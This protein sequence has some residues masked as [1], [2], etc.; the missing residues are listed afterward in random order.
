[1]APARI[2]A[3]LTPPRHVLVLFG[4]SIED[5]TWTE[6]DLSRRDSTVEPLPIQ[7]PPELGLRLRIIALQQYRELDNAPVK[8]CINTSIVHFSAAKRKLEYASSNSAR[9]DWQ[10][11]VALHLMV[12][13]WILTVMVK[14]RFKSPT[15]ISGAEAKCGTEPRVASLIRRVEKA[16]TSLLLI[17]C[18]DLIVCRSCAVFFIQILCKG[19]NRT[20]RK[21]RKWFLA[22]T[23]IHLSSGELLQRSFNTH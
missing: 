13:T 17:L 10:P 7:V 16:S 14:P 5:R 11:E 21:S 20:R 15:T 1:M 4:G 23:R 8:D 9:Q 6:W 2:G 12:S 19:L 22:L 18:F 3:H